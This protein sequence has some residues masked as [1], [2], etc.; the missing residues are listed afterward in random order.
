[1]SDP[2]LDSIDM[3]ILVQSIK[4]GGAIDEGRRFLQRLSRMPRMNRP[5]SAIASRA[6]GITSAAA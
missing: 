2:I 4:E 6:S 1:M 5:I 3:W